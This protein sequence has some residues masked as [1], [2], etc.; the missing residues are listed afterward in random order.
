M[1][2]FVFIVFITLSILPTFN[3]YLN[4]GILS[5]LNSRSIKQLFSLDNILY[6]VNPFLVEHGISTSPDSVIVGYDDWLFLGDQY[7]ST[8]SKNRLGSDHIEVIERSNNIIS[9][10]D[11]WDSFFRSKGVKS[12]SI[13]LGPNKSTVYS[14]KLPV[15]A[16]TPDYS[17]SHHLYNSPIYV[18]SIDDLR[19]ARKTAETYYRT[20]THWNSYGASVAFENYLNKLV[21]D[22]DINLPPSSWSKVSHI[23]I[24]KG[25]DL[26]R[27]LGI[28]AVTNDVEV[29]TGINKTSNHTVYDYND[30]DIIYSGSQKNFGN[31]HD[32]SLIENKH[33]LNDIKVLW[34]S[35]SFG[36]ALLPYMTDTFR[37]VL[38]QH[39]SQVIGR[40]KLPELVLDWKPDLV[41]YTIVERSSL[42]EVFTVRPPTYADHELTLSSLSS[43]SL[44]K[45]HSI[46]SVDS[47]EFE[48]SGQNPLLI[49]ELDNPNVNI[50]SSTYLQLDFQCT[51]E[52]SNNKSYPI[53]VYWKA[54]EENFKEES[55]VR[56][57]IQD[58]L[59]Q[60]ALG[61]VINPLDASYLRVDF[62][63]AGACNKFIL[64]SLD[65]G[66]DVDAFK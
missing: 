28:D 62:G 57:E 17:L 16:K 46:N 20:D 9:S 23:D 50:I 32:L 18:N 14:D 8:I 7:A 55:S 58:G 39:W 60:I 26:S 56:V 48:L 42:E 52:L 30:G 33:A 61:N 63:N 44:I 11:K 41:L 21:K 22:V 43:L 65:I 64:T 37:S 35:D 38:K 45:S 59:N 2:R 25:G 34:L 3:F 12:F 47:V 19:Y 29:F 6:R 10:L 66:E 27:F 24:R 4:P 51:D 5:E 13:I 40:S 15:W 1:I 54:Q 31:N 53:Q 49:Y 36:D